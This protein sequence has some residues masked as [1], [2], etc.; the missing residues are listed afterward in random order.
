M[1]PKEYLN[2]Y[3]WAKKLI[4]SKQDEIKQLEVLAEYV[5]PGIESGGGGSAS[6]KVGKLAAK[7]ADEKDKLNQQIEE[8][9]NLKTEIKSCIAWIDNKRYRF[10]LTERY[11]NCKRWNEIAEDNHYSVR[12][13]HY[14]HQNALNAFGRKNPHIKTLH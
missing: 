13:V 3:Y 12:S 6:D 4:E 7:I 8:L 5:S 14:L 11:I 2:Q 9:V 1:T 10:V